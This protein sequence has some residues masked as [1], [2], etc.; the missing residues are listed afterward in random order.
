[1]SFSVNTNIA[2]LQ[3]QEYIRQNSDFQAKTINRVTSGLRIISSGDDAAGLAIANGFRSDQAVLTQ[4]I[5]NANDGLSQLQIID[6]GINNISKLLD[7]ARTL[8][9]QSA[10]GTFTGSRAVLSSEFTSVIGEIDRQAQAIGLNTGG[11]F[12]KSLSVFV[13]GGRGA[14]GAAVIANGA[15]GVDLTQSTVDAKSLGLKGVQAAGLS[16][17]DIG[18]GSAS[19]SVSAI[20]GNAT[21]TGSLA[22]AGFSDF[23]FR[24]AGFGDSNRVKVSVNLGGVTDTDTLVTN[25]NAAIDA[26]GAGASQYATAFKNA[27]VRATVI[28][29]AT[30]TKQ[31]GFT[32]STSAFQVSAGDRLSNALIGNVTSSSDPTGLTLANT[33]TGGAATAATTTAFGASGAGTVT[34]RIQGGGLSGP[35][36]IDLTTLAATTIDSALTTLSS[37]VS[38]NSAL[39]AAG[40]TVSTA[41]AGSA[42]VFT[43][44]RGESLDVSASGDLNNLLG[45]GS[46]Q[47]SAEASGTFDYTTVTGSG[48]TYAA[49]AA[50][51]EFSIGGGP[52]ISTSFTAAGATQTD[53]LLALNN[54]IASDATLSAAG[55]LA[56]DSG[57]EINITSSNGTAFRINSV[58]AA[59]VLGFNASVAT[60]VA[61]TDQ[62]QSALT[63]S[64]VIESGGAQQTGVLAFSPIRLGSDEQTIT[65]SGNDSSGVS[66]SLSV[67]LRN[68]GTARNARTVDEAIDAIN[69]KLQ[70]SNNSTLQKIVAVKEQNGGAE[71]IRFIS[72]VGSFKVDV[73]TNG[74]A[75]GVGSQGTV[76]SSSTVGTGSTAD[77]SSQSAAQNAVGA[78][79]TAVAALG[80]AQAVVGKG[81]NNFNY[82]VNLAQNQLGNLA[83]SESRIRDADLASEAANLTKAQITLQAGIAALGQANSAPQAILALLRG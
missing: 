34:V 61:A 50:T 31:L 36:D 46:F 67:V 19:T 51:L 26:A 44:S 35:V 58:G 6:G 16:T 70:Q 4:G 52:V 29:S 64:A 30:G 9:T 57:G 75:S 10:S 20:L 2:S 66:Q 12:A 47:R 74:S 48:A 25:I 80:T 77:I 73:G 81:Q 41:T 54:A 5:R 63:T 76:A 13:G 3:A 32:S 38:A 33:V 82:A 23:Y 72:T 11:D 7:R 68:D 83:A 14:T 39:Q 18:T 24:G 78:L 22:T 37:A 40:I 43:N 42:L 60:G 8:A 56:T 69:T 17:I 55:L 45:L 53:T 59:N 1:M 49:A 65:I 79:A 27:G 62:T 28:T 21:N 71:G 15:V